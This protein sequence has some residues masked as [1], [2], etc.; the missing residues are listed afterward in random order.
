MNESIKNNTKCIVY[1]QK[2]IWDETMNAV[3]A[4]IAQGGNKTLCICKAIVQASEQLLSEH[5][6]EYE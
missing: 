3:E 2:Q 5:P 4:F 1:I 6:Q